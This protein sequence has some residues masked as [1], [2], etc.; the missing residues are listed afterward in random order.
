MPSNSV[1][2]G[3]NNLSLA[4]LAE[5]YKEKKNE[6]E[7]IENEMENKTEKLDN[8]I[9]RLKK[10]RNSIETPYLEKIENYKDEINE[11]ENDMLEHHRGKN[12]KIRTE[13]CN[14]HFKTG[15]AIK[16]KNKE[17]TVEI[18]KNQGMLN[19]GIKIYKKPIGKLIEDGMID[20][21]TAD[22]E[23]TKY[24]SISDYLDLEEED[25][26]IY[27]KLHNLRNNIARNRNT[28]KYYVFSNETLRRLA[29]HKPKNEKEMKK[30]KGVGKNNFNKYGDR[31]INLL[32]EVS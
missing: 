21:E 6:L 25:K 16:I 13:F 23:E 32:K 26:K 3:E 5:K 4:E 31:F 14:I 28:K 20:N 19:E 27:K 24:V 30:I 22:F 12:E 8:K 10:K 11:I 18:L 1:D 2:S 9:T 15:K 29:K 7:K 17:K